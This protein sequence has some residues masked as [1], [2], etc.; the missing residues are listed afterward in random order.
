MKLYRRFAAR[1]RCKLA[2]D[3]E[4]KPFVAGRGVSYS[5]VSAWPYYWFRRGHQSVP[6][7][8][9]VNHTKKK[10]G[11]DFLAWSDQGKPSSLFVCQLCDQHQS[12]RERNV[13]WQMSGYLI[14]KTVPSKNIQA[15]QAEVSHPCHFDK[16]VH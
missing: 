16:G 6:K 8:S 9:I 10:L 15:H 3:S 2:P 12:C 13:S 5:F 14:H 7:D 4:G 11:L 1:T